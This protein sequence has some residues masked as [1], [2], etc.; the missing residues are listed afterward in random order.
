MHPVRISNIEYV[1]VDQVQSHG[2]HV[3]SPQEGFL[4]LLACRQDRQQD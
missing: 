3:Q 2:E 1:Q 4:D